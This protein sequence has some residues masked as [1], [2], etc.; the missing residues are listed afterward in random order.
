M[1]QHKINRNLHERLQD[2]Q[3]QQLVALLVSLIETHPR[4]DIFRKQF[5]FH[6]ETMRAQWLAKPLE[7]SFLDEAD[8]FHKLFDSAFDRPKL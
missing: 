7:E 6:V 5:N 3:A 8:M 2:I 1:E 4:P